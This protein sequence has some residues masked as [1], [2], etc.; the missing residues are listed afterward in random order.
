MVLFKAGKTF[1]QICR[2]LD[3]ISIMNFIVKKESVSRFF[4]N[5]LKS[6]K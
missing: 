6:I 5:E 3:N 2:K 4:F 1:E